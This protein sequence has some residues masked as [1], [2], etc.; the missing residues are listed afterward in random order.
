MLSSQLLP[1]KLCVLHF[2]WSCCLG[3]WSFGPAVQNTYALHM[4]LWSCK[5]LVTIYKHSHSSA[6]TCLVH[7]VLSKIKGQ[8]F[9]PC[10]QELQ[11]Y[12]ATRVS[13]IILMLRTRFAIIHKTFST[14]LKAIICFNSSGPL[15]L[16][17]SLIDRG[18]GGGRWGSCWGPTGVCNYLP[19]TV[20]EERIQSV[21]SQGSKGEKLK[22]KEKSQG[23]L[24]NCDDQQCKK[25]WL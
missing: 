24:T 17:A 23:H 4:L 1:I 16:S 20:H 9:D 22:Y 21:N 15:V 7:S 14:I 5:V 19:V 8:S 11:M 25:D 18:G 10:R 3:C 12:Q 6:L 2:S 13:N